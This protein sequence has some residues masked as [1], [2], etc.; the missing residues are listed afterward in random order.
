MGKYDIT[1]TSI[2]RHVLLPIWALYEVMTHEPSEDQYG[3]SC[4]E[5]GC[6]ICNAGDDA[7]V[8][9]VELIEKGWDNG[10]DEPPTTRAWPDD[11]ELLMALD[12]VAAELCDVED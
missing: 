1:L 5:R 9:L 4:D 12:N 10:P 8:G 6:F 7:V 3:Y 2:Q 11:R